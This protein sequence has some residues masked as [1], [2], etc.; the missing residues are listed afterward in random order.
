LVVIVGKG[1]IEKK[2]N[3]VLKEEED[4]EVMRKICK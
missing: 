3:Y 2:K 4:C 1:E